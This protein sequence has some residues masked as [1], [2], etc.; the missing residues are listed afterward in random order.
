MEVRLGY[1]KSQIA[2]VDT[3]IEYLERE[4]LYE[5]TPSRSSNCYT[6]A[7]FVP[8]VPAE[9]DEALQDIAYL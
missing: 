5:N 4:N 6:T 9:Q 2:M 1:P 7:V 8:T 3:V